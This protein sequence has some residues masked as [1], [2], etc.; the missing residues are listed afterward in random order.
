MSRPVSIYTSN[1]ASGGDSAVFNLD[2]GWTKV[3]LDI[4]SMS[5]TAALTVYGGQDASNLRILHNRIDTATVSFVTYIIQAVYA[6]TIVPIPSG[7]QHMKVVAA[8]VVS[9]GV[10]MSILAS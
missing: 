7:F 6:N 4:G 1:I 3:Y 5:T 8:A 9:G 2:H 10:S